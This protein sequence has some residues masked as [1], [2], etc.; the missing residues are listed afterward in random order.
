MKA[1]YDLS[2]MK[3]RGHPLRDKVQR[4]EIVLV[5]PFEISKGELVGRFVD[6]YLDKQMTGEEYQEYLKDLKQ[7]VTGDYVLLSDLQERIENERQEGV[8]SVK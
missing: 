8:A 7:V 2:K 3:S 6:D 1:E 4:G 5:N